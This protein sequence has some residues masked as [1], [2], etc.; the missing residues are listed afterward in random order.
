MTTVI[1]STDVQDV[2]SYSTDSSFTLTMTMKV[3]N[4]VTVAVSADQRSRESIITPMKAQSK[5]ESARSWH[6]FPARSVGTVP[7]TSILTAHSCGIDFF[8]KP[9]SS[10]CYTVCRCQSSV[11]RI[12]SCSKPIQSIGSEE[13]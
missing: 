6:P 1:T 3:L 13:R 12:G 5:R 8:L 2:A 7:S 9:I 11:A 4:P 10:I